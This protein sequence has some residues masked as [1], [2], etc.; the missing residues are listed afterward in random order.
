[1]MTITARTVVVGAAQCADLKD[2]SEYSL[3]LFGQ[4]VARVSDYSLIRNRSS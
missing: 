2:A 1:M 3:E 4:R